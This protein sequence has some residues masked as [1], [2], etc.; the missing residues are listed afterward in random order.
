VMNRSICFGFG[1]RPW[2]DNGVTVKSVWDRMCE[3]IGRS[4]Q[5]KWILAL[6]SSILIC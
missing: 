1:E 3:S 4:L 5:K 6:G 2:A